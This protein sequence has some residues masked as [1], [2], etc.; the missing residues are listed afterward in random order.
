MVG[1]SE[2]Q[3]SDLRI[4]ERSPYLEVYSQSARRKGHEAVEKLMVSPD[5]GRS[6]IALKSTSDLRRIGA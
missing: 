2:E 6:S 5:K 3:Q 1:D 4:L